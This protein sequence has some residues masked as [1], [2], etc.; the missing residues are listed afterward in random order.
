MLSLL[1][2]DLLNCLNSIKFKASF[3][4][5]YCISMG[6]YYITLYSIKGLSNMSLAIIDR[7][8]IINGMYGRKL[9]WLFI[10]CMPLF[11]LMIYSD[12]FLIEKQNKSYINIVQRVG[13][14][15]YVLSKFIT[16]A[17]VSF[18]TVFFILMINE[19][20]ISIIFYNAGSATGSVPIYAFNHT[21]ISILEN[22][23]SINPFIGKI[24][25]VTMASLVAMSI[26]VFTLSLSY[27]IKV[28]N[29]VLIATV[30]IAYTLYDFILPVELTNKMSID[31]MIQGGGESIVYFLLIIGVIMFISIL[32]TVRA[33]K[34]DFS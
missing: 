23:G 21:S 3:I 31:L 33:T 13:R 16:T 9:W 25:L 6:S 34:I 20:T 14:K 5:L 1:K 12:S 8:G 24:I 19:M 22:F 29:Y 30:Y 4:I 28:K 27:L 2:L 17:L 32:F 11:V 10:M 26:S 18:L 7:L 15:K